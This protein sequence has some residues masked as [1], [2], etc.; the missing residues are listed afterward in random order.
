MLHLLC[1]HYR[2]KP[3]ISPSNG[4]PESESDAPPCNHRVCVGNDLWCVFRRPCTPVR[5]TKLQSIE[6]CSSC[7][8][9]EYALPTKTKIPA[10]EK[11]APIAQPMDKQVIT[12][13][14]P[15]QRNWDA[16][17]A[18]AIA[19][20]GSKMCPFSETRVFSKQC[21]LCRAREPKKY[22]ECVHLRALIAINVQ[23]TKSGQ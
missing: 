9:Q 2:E 4:T 23:N 19:S 6:I 11:P 7:K 8:S 20:D 14:L 15:T 16:K 22:D 5:Q 1:N 18:N 10:S 17:F 13:S 21:Y 3:E 12:L